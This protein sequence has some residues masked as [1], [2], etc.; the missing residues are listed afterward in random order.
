MRKKRAIR[1]FAGIIF[2]CLVVLIF[3]IISFPL[4]DSDYN[5][6]GFARGID[7][8][9][10]YQGGAVLTYNVYSDSSLNGSASSGLNAT[11]TRLENLLSDKSYSAN[12]YKTSNSSIKIE[13]LFNGFDDEFKDVENIINLDNSLKFK[14]DKDDT[15]YLN[16]YDIENVVAYNNRESQ[17]SDNNWGIL[18][19]FT[20]EGQ[21]K[22]TE[23][24]TKLAEN[25]GTVK[26][27]IGDDSDDSNVISSFSISEKYENKSIFISGGTM[28]DEDGAKSMAEQFNSTRYKYSFKQTSKVIISKDRAN[29]NL[30]LTAVIYTL[31][32]ALIVAFLYARFRNLG[33]ISG[34]LC[35]LI[36]CLAQILLMMSIPNIVL[37]PTS[38]IACI[39]TMVMGGAISSIMFE[40][41]R[42]EYA[43]GKKIHASVKSGFGKTYAYILDFLGLTS[44]SSFVL[45]IAGTEMI[46]QFAGAFLIGTV[47]YGLSSL[48]LS[49]LFAKFYVDINPTNSKKYGFKREGHINELN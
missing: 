24:S 35:M 9:V 17:T 29:T 27:Y 37:S 46:K 49:Y 41:M 14:I 15:V 48:L 47:V 39:L 7:K 34:G 18:I 38:F 10:E 36:A 45:L 3:T 25:S 40:K 30:I 11:T 4:P 20:D 5:F 43:L 26:I 28:S 13:T 42:K 21:T 33:L 19:T 23:L 1:N 12:V 6:V 8:S 2:L 44:M 31:T 16:G 22:F 32:F